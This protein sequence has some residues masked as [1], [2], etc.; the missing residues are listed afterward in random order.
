ML[1]ASEKGQRSRTPVSVLSLQFLKDETQIRGDEEEQS[2]TT[3]P[4]TSSTGCEGRWSPREP[5]ELRC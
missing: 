5:G 1:T 2:F 3:Y 4:P